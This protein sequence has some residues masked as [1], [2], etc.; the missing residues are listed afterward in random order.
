MASHDI[1][2]SLYWKYQEMT[3]P[4]AVDM[5]LV[6]YG[7]VAQWNLNPP[8]PMHDKSDNIATYLVLIFFWIKHLYKNICIWFDQ[9]LFSTQNNHLKHK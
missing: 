3:K 1:L 2:V 5:H 6:S 4:D 8:K 9:Y 7:C